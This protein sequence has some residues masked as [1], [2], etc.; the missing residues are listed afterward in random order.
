[1]CGYCED[2]IGIDTFDFHKK[3]CGE[4]LKSK[5]LNYNHNNSGEF[6]N[7]YEKNKNKENIRV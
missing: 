3:I 5:N 6:S 7:I 1:M 4:L 2:K